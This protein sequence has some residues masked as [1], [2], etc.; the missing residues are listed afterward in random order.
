MSYVPSNTNNYPQGYPPGY[1][2]PGYPPGHPNGPPVVAPAPLAV[3]VPI[4]PAPIVVPT[5]HTHHVFSQQ[6]FRPAYNR[7]GMRISVNIPFPEVPVPFAIPRPIPVHVPLLPAVEHRYQVTTH[8]HG[9]AFRII[10]VIITMALS[11]LLLTPIIC[12]YFFF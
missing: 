10:A 7:P 5:T 2:P 4:Q 3:Q 1:Y 8:T 9:N 11:L 6:A 12:P